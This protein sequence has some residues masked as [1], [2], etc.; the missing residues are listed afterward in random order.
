SKLLCNSGRSLEVE[1]HESAFLLCG[2]AVAPDQEVAE[3]R[4]ADLGA[5]R[6]EHRQR[7]I[8]DQRAEEQELHGAAEQVAYVVDLRRIDIAPDDVD[9]VVG[10]GHGGKREAADDEQV[11]RAQ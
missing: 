5:Q 4:V 7:E 11:K 6:V 9:P 2:L 1:E 3:V 8:A 10:I